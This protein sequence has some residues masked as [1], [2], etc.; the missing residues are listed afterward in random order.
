M[1]GLH[2]SWL[3]SVPKSQFLH[4]HRNC[5]DTDTFKTQATILKKRFLEKGYDCA[6]VDKDLNNDLVVD[7]SLLLGEKPQW[8]KDQNFKWSF[9]TTFSTQHKQI[10]NIFERHWDI[11]RNDKIFAPLLPNRSTE[12]YHPLK[13]NWHLLLLILQVDLLSSTIG[14]DSI[15]VGNVWFAN[16]IP[17]VEGPTRNFDRLW[18]IEFTKSD[19]SAPVQLL[20]LY[21]CWLVHA[22]NNMLAE[23][24]DLL[25]LGWPNTLI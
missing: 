2:K 3:R 23:L 19:S 7:R 17:V 25:P 5:T 10:K 12:G 13:V 4:L 18:L 11:L 22:V 9:L 16:I 15:R 20:T 14:R 1:G 6:E 8:E 24:Q 21:T